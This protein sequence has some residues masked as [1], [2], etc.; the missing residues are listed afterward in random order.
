MVTYQVAGLTI[1]V[2]ADLPVSAQ[3]FA[4]KFDQFLASQSDGDLVKIYH[5]FTLPPLSKFNLD[6]QVYRE[7]PWAIYQDG[8]RWVYLGIASGENDLSPWRLAV[9]NRDHTEGQI[10]S[11]DQSE[12]LRGNLHS[13]T[14]FPTDQIVLS[15]VLAD[16][17]GCY[18]HS[19]GMI[20]NGQG[21]L[22][23]GH[24]GAGKSTMTKLLQG[25]GEILC[26]DRVI[27]RRWPVG[28]K[29][30]G[31]WSHGEIPIVSN[32]S[33]PLRAI[34]LLEQASHN[35]LIPIRERGETVRRLPFFIIKPLV[36]ADWWQ[37][38]LDLVGQIAREVPVYRLQFDKSGQVVNLVNELVKK[39]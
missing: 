34:L 26:D 33:A 18:F 39:S 17:Q 24:S 27:L 10:Y 20:I 12:F 31:S 37:K 36:T 32:A 14:L 3:T 29:V 15:W 16:R 5:H 8:L 22:F 21:L 30:H 13:L 9:F 11:P 38:T 25:E 35:R 19:S 1:Q 2:S 4:P 23:V 7:A 28:F 6:S